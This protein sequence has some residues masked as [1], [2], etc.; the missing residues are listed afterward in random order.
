MLVDSVV[1]S[2]KTVVNSVQHILSLYATIHIVAVAGIVQA[3]SGSECS[4]AQALTTCHTV[5]ALQYPR[6]LCSPIAKQMFHCEVCT[7]SV[8]R[9][10]NVTSI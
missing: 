9:T 6:E 2:G 5:S 3:Q 4:F 1:N 10:Q 8:F 7:T